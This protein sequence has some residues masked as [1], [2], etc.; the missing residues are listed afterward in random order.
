M[1]ARFK[2]KRKGVGQMLRMPGMQA[3]MLRRAEVIKGVAIGL[4]PVDESSPDPGHYK[5]SWETDSTHRGGRRRD[6]A[7]ATVRNTAYYARWVE[8]GTERV[9]AHHVLLRAAQLGG[10][11][12]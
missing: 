8:Y 10:R 9:P 1:A 7:T 5:A 2:V 6:R 11:N 3:E 12:Q 4:S